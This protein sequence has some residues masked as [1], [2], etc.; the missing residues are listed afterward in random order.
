LNGKILTTQV[1]FSGEDV[2]VRELTAIEVSRLLDT[3]DAIP[4]VLDAYM[5]DFDLPI[6]AVT[7]SSGLTE[8]QLMAETGSELEELYTAVLHVNPRFAALTERLRKIVE[9]NTANLLKDRAA[10]S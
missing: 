5:S 9:M 10:N 8:E 6:S 2:T 7:I 1:S 4:H 3:A